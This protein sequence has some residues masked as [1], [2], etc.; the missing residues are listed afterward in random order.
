MNRAARRA[1]ERK[2]LG[3][4]EKNWTASLIKDTDVMLKTERKK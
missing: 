1:A 2:P 3:M 4:R